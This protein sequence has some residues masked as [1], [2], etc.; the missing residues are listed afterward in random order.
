M[1][2]SDRSPASPS[3]PKT[4]AGGLRLLHLPNERRLTLRQKQVGPR[5]AFTWMQETGVLER[6]DVF[7]YL[8]EAAQNGAAATRK[9][10]RALVDECRPDLIFWQH[11]TDFEVTT[12]FLRELKAADSQPKLVYHDGDPYGRF[13][14]RMPRPMRTI[15]PEA[16][17]VFL[18][19]TGSF[20]DLARRYGAQTIRF[21][22]HC[23]DTI[24]YGS[25]WTPTTSR[26]Y[27]LVMIAN[28]GGTRIPGRHLPGARM[29]HRLV[30][31][32]TD[33]FGDRFALYG[34]GWGDLPSARGRVPFLDQEKAIREAWVSVNWDHFDDVPFYHSDRL[35]IS[36][37]TG[38]PHVT[39][40][41]PGYD[42]LC[43]DCES[44][45]TV[46]TIDEAVDTV[47][48]LLSL[49]PERLNEMGEQGRRFAFE[50]FEANV[51]YGDIIRTC[52]Q[53]L[54]E[55]EAPSSTVLDSAKDDTKTEESAAV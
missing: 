39:C 6:Y 9:R 13:I 11:N 38:V 54:F 55:D 35:P 31:A 23:F 16:D 32:L 4:E 47:R 12:D 24:R 5:K 46:S 28:Y 42:A 34:K 43:G 29:R 37:A 44:L 49:P 14:K 19:G 20:F 53:L 45:F 41:H 30:E 7:S 18:V 33:E 25:S 10:L 27:D 50:R 36:L 52:Q 3:S 40:H 15:L 26:P 21:A 1:P 8:W 51:V 17:L 22:P 48:Y 2:L